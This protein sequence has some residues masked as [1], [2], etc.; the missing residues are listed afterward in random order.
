MNLYSWLRTIYFQPKK[1][2]PLSSNERPV[3]PFGSASNSLLLQGFI[4]SLTHL[5]KFGG[6]KKGS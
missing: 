3:V 5:F 6:F 1:S 2:F 4:R